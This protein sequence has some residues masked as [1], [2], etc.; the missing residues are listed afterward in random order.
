MS[1]IKEDLSVFAFEEVL[2]LL[3]KNPVAN[4]PKLLDLVDKIPTKADYKKAI[5]LVREKVK[6][7]DSNWTKLIVKILTSLHPNVR[8][9]FL[10]NFL[11]RSSLIGRPRML[12]NTQKYGCNIPWTILMDP[13]SACN[14]KCI[15][16]WAGEYSKCD[17]L[18]FEDLDSI[19]MQGKELGMRMFMYSGG[20][21]L[22][23]KKD[24]IRLCEKHQDCAFLSFTNGTLIDE[25]FAQEV[26]RVGNIVFAISIEGFED[27]TDMRRGKGT[28]QQVIRAMDILREAGVGFGYSCCYHS[29]N[30]DSIASDEFVDYMIEKGCLFAWYFTYIPVGKDAATELIATPQQ[31]KYMYE[32]IREIR[33]TKPFFALDFWNDGEY[34]DGCIAGGRNYFHINAHGDCEP[35]AF[36]HYS[37]VNIKEVSLLEALKSPL[38]QQYQSHQPFNHNHLRP[39]P[40]MDNPDKLKAMVHKAGAQSTQPVDK[41]PVDELTDKVQHVSRSWGKV[42]DEIWNKRA[43]KSKIR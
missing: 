23:R 14:L 31:R 37:N 39:C 32:R 33:A 16:C 11:I 40:L 15:G 24:I 5:R 20:E 30:T 38:F 21:P 2:T 3:D 8:K 22:V 25:E 4:I 18:S 36:I 9:V 7:P 1:T 29:K 10:P 28:Y 43:V 17:S 13:T 26:V 19:I 12:S 34:V 6:D 42:A 27:A 41:E 35:C